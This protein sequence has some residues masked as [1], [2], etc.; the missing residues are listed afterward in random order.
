MTTFATYPETTLYPNPKEE[1]ARKKQLAKDEDLAS[2][3]QAMFKG[4]YG[5]LEYYGGFIEAKALMF[6]DNSRA[7]LNLEDLKQIGS[8]AVIRCWKKQEEATCGKIKNF[9]IFVKWSIENAYRTIVSKEFSIRRGRFHLQFLSELTLETRNGEVDGFE[10]VV[11][12]HLGNEGV[13]LSGNRSGLCNLV[14]AISEFIPDVSIRETFVKISQTENFEVLSPGYRLTPIR[15]RNLSQEIGVPEEN[16]PSHL[17]SIQF[18]THGFR[19]TLTK[20]KT[21]R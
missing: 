10:E 9:D 17:E 7:T 8:M 2:W 12:H 1:K 5:V 13:C 19:D 11:H 4:I 15:R 3:E 18:V 16:I 20:Q 21:W 6:R 14:S